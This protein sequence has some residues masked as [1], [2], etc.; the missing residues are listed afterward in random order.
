MRGLLLTSLVIVAGCGDAVTLPSVETSSAHFRYFASSSD[1]IPSDVLDRLEQHRTDILGFF[2]ISDERIINYY[3]FDRV[4]DFNRLDR[5]QESLGCTRGDELFT[6][7][8]FDQHELIHAY[9]SD[10]QPGFLIA[11]G[12]AEAF[13]CGEAVREWVFAPPVELSWPTVVGQ[14]PGD[15]DV[16]RWE[17][18]SFSTSS[19]PMALAG[20]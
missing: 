12:T 1:R 8:A 16:Y 15:T 11:E 6:T 19:E 3:R 5:C 20:F 4:E 2:G 9:L 10:W 17:S 7:L 13:H 14:S 18:G